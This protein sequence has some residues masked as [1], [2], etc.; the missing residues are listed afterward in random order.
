MYN[1]ICLYS[2]NVC[3]KRI[4]TKNLLALTVFVWCDAV[5]SPFFSLF[6]DN[7]NATVYTPVYKI[8]T[9]EEEIEVVH[10]SETTKA[11]SATKGLILNIH[12]EKYSHS[13]DPV[14]SA[15]AATY[16]T[17]V[18]SH[19]V[20]NLWNLYWYLLDLAHF[21][22]RVVSLSNNNIQMINLLM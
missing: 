13:K 17:R 4:S 5:G 3:Y 1:L 15:D 21:T 14:E 2:T 8:S 6:F 9:W 19:R 10:L 12:R 20:W 18:T 11:K 7:D 22:L 16:T